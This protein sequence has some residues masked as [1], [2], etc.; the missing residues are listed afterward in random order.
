M[1]LVHAWFVYVFS[2]FLYRNSSSRKYCTKIGA[3]APFYCVLFLCGSSTHTWTNSLCHKLNTGE[4][5]SG[6]AYEWYTNGPQIVFL[7]VI[8]SCNLLLSLPCGDKEMTYEHNLR[9][10]QYASVANDLHICFCVNLYQ[11]FRCHSYWYPS[12]WAQYRCDN[13]KKCYCAYL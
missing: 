1:F 8:E 13:D 5:P 2:E 4:T 11:Y 9:L 12:I 10:T 3:G 6:N 7:K